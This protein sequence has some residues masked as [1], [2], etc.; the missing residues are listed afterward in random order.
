M[1]GGCHANL[2]LTRK[3]GRAQSPPFHD[4]SFLLILACGATTPT[5]QVTT[6]VGQTESLEPG[7]TTHSIVYAGLERTYLLHIPAS[8]DAVRATPLV[9]AF[10]GIG[11]NAEEM[12]RI[13][14][15]SEQADTS[16]FIIAYPNGIGEKK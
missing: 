15:L 5:Q 3:P 7:D 2:Q 8:L 13:S 4:S 9:L 14:G 10:H 1:I 12:A 6:P 11:L 16:G